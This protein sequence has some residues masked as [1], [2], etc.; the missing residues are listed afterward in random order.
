MASNVNCFNFLRKIQ[1]NGFDQKTGSLSLLEE[2]HLR[3]TPHQQGYT[4]PQDNQEVF[5][6]N[7]PKKQAGVAT[8]KCD[9]IDFKLNF[10]RRDQKEKNPLRGHYN[11]KHLCTK[12]KGTKTHKRK[13]TIVKTTN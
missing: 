12:H 13:T 9:K 2:T 5:Q 6:M 11:S 10:V 1:T 7:G 3:N 8:F 4:S